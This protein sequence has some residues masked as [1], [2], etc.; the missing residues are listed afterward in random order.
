MNLFLKPLWLLYEYSKKLYVLYSNDNIRNK[1]SV[2]LKKYI[3]IINIHYV[4]HFT[5][6]KTTRTARYRNGN[7]SQSH[8]IH[9]KMSLTP[10]LS[11]I[12]HNIL[13]RNLFRK[14]PAGI[15]LPWKSLK[16]PILVAQCCE[17]SDVWFQ[18]AIGTPT[19]PNYWP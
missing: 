2:K 9:V 5:F 11:Y 18:L 17:K 10:S 14:N 15:N 7:R 4:S 16:K 13:L 6:K 19:K 3:V 1:E 8:R 12:D